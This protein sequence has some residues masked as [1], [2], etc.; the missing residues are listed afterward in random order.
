[1]Q[2]AKAQAPAHLKLKTEFAELKGFTG[3]QDKLKQSFL[4]I[5]INAYQAMQKSENPSLDVQTSQVGSII[6][7]RIKDGGLGM[8]EEVSHQCFEP[9]FSTK[10][11]GGTGLGLAMV[12]GVVRRHEGSIDIKS[13]EGKGSTFSIR[14]PIRNPV[15]DRKEKVAVLELV[16]QVTKKLH[17]LVVD[18]ESMVREVL[19]EYLSG[20]G[21]E[22]TLAKDGLEALGHF[23]QKKFDL[24]ITDRAMP[25]MNGD[26][27]AEAVKKISPDTPLIML[28]GFGEL[29]KAKEECPKGV[30]H[31]ISKPL[32]FEGYRD[33]LAKAVLK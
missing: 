21:H 2:L 5:I 25:E 13:Q 8:S 22:V 14:F 19:Q 17:V 1:M 4:N 20:D 16:G 24:V 15:V 32:T 30:D 31:L 23:K 26:Q 9:F 10:G 18:D 33:A 7:V 11:R 27:L 29:M 6:T 28:T 3:S 12:Y